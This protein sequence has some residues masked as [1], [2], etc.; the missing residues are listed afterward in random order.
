MDESESVSF[1]ISVALSRFKHFHTATYQ[2]NELNLSKYLLLRR[3]WINDESIV[4][5]DL[6]HYGK[7]H[8][9]RQ[10]LKCYFDVDQE[11]LFNR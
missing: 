9:K 11:S 4:M 10:L 3:P 6:F 1:S 7:R 5:R 8:T 2:D